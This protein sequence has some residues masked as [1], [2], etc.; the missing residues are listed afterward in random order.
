MRQQILAHEMERAHE[1]GADTVSVLHISPLRNVD[2][3]KVTSP[4]L[5]A[6]GETA[7]GVWKS[8]VRPGDRFISAS[9]GQLFGGLSADQSNGMQAWLDY[10]FARYQWVRAGHSSALMSGH[11]AVQRCWSEHGNCR[12]C[13]PGG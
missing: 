13:P 2:F 3:R 6:L 11:G 12:G 10:V 9:T 8:L 7:T 4:E 1:L 5:E